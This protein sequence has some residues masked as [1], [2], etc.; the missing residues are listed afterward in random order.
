MGLTHYSLTISWSRIIPDGDGP[1]NQ[2]GLDFY[3]D[4]IRELKKNG[5]R[6]Y[7]TLYHWEL[8]SALQ[9]HG[10][11][12][13][14][15]AVVPQFER[16]A[17]IVFSGLADE[18]VD[19]WASMN[20]PRV[21][22]SGGYMWGDSPP[23][24]CSN[25]QLCPE[26]DDTTEPYICGHNA[27]LA[28]AAA[29]N[30][31]RTE[32]A[33]KHSSVKIGIVLDGQWI[34]PMT[35]RPRDVEAARRQRVID[36]GWFAHPLWLGDYPPEMRSAMPDLPV[37]SPDE[38]ASIKGTSDYFALDYYTA[39]YGFDTLQGKP[40]NKSSPW[41]PSC[42]GLSLTRNGTLIGPVTGHKHFYSYP[43]GLRKN[44]KWISDT[45]KPAY[46]LV[47]EN[48]HAAINE[49]S[50]TDERALNDSSRI[51]HFETH[52]EA[53]RQVVVEDDVDV[54]GFFAWSFIDNLEWVLGTTVRFGLIRVDFDKNA[55]RRWKDSAYWYCGKAR[56]LVGFTGAC[57]MPS[58]VV[59]E[60]TSSV[61]GTALASGTSTISVMATAGPLTT[62]GPS[63]GRRVERTI[64]WTGLVAA[65]LALVSLF[66]F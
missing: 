52:L 54:R 63:S 4:L 57:E 27:L 33:P 8:P 29:V 18:G 6:V 53:V 59:V 17:R 50:W 1:I 55:T 49:S 43:E 19:W 36:I 25:R 23:G 3:R 48:G 51:E 64:G 62:S 40:C 38:I 41:W 45:Y 9:V 28:H 13:N 58:L 14:R 21:F 61:T 30:V 56:E 37:F 7:A 16:Y 32:F 47:T 65:S 5:L 31:W 42:S 34:E 22:C 66:P 11:W 20:E 10:G 44:L 12:L 60:T 15:S 26:G 39:V 35:T 24:R 2:K 46:L